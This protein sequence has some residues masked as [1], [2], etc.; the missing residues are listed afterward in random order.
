MPRFPTCR[1]APVS[2]RQY[3]IRCPSQRGISPNWARSA[4]VNSRGSPAGR[5]ATRSAGV[6]IARRSSTA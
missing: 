1:A 4:V 6:R 5:N 3:A 2:R